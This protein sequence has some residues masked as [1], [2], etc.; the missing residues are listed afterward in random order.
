MLLMNWQ[1]RVRKGI[2]GEAGP[3]GLPGPKGDLGEPG[4]SGIDVSNSEISMV[5]LVIVLHISILTSYYAT[6]PQVRGGDGQ[7]YVLYV[8]SVSWHLVSKTIDKECHG[9]QLQPIYC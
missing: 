5:C 8:L 3:R 9:R 4:L 1:G 7:L 6:P 2:A